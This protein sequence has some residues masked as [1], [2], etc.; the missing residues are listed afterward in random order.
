MWYQWWK[1]YQ[2][3]KALS[4]IE[5]WTEAQY[6]EGAWYDE[7]SIQRSVEEVERLMRPLTI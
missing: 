5:N 1:K 6:G 7:R 3:G 2:D 4:E